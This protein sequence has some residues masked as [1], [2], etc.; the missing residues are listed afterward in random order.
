M[1]FTG[2]MTGSRMDVGVHLLRLDALSRASFLYVRNKFVHGRVFEAAT[3]SILAQ[4]GSQGIRLGGNLIMTRLLAPE[5]FGLMSIVFT[6]Q[7]VLAL[8]SDIGLRPAVFQSHRGDDPVFLNTVWTLQVLRGLGMFVA[9]IL[10]AFGMHVASRYDVFGPHTALGSPQLPSVL[11]VT[12]I[13]AAIGGFQS[14]NYITAGRNLNLRGIIVIDAIAQVAGLLMM[15]VLGIMTGSIWSLVFG[16]LFSAA[17]STALSH[18]YLPGIANR[19][20]VN[21]EAFSEISK[22]GIW[23]LVSS[24]AYVLSLNLD[25]MYLGAVITATSLGI[26]AI[27][28]SL[29]QAV[30]GLI[31]RLFESVLL[32][33]LSEAARTSKEKLRAQIKRLRLPFDLWYLGTAGLLYTLGPNIIDFLYDH[34]YQEAGPLLQILSFSLIFA[35]YSVFNVAYL[36][37]GKSGYQ[38]A[39]NIIKLATIAILLPTFFNYWGIMGAAY[40]VA[41][42]PIATLPLHFWLIRKLGLLDLKYELLVLPIWPAGYLVGMACVELTRLMVG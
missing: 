25:R 8:L 23:I 5:M 32:P 17:I 28:L 37:V 42:H 1:P 35:R 10:I 40:A 19:L 39:I 12:S 33:V 41:L 11:V 31:S 36:A 21:R 4:F 27:A 7:M 22:F 3:L 2:A 38:A 14:S 30:D 16:G 26:Y 9:C 34:R 20:V 15:I 18:K 24:L 13:A 6:I 29:Y